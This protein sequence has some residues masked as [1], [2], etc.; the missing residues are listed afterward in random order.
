MKVN[1]GT[2]IAEY[3]KHFTEPE[4]DDPRFPCFTG[5]VKTIKETEGGRQS[6]SKIMEEYAKEYAKEVSID[7]IIR[8][9]LKHH[10]ATDQIVQDLIEEYGFDT[11]AALERI[12]AV[13]SKPA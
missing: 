13:K 6:M 12:E 7:S 9:Q 1:D 4:F 5:A 10:V 11:A 8:I 2:T 3:M